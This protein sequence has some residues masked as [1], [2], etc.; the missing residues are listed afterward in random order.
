L[1]ASRSSVIGLFTSPP[2]SIF[3]PSVLKF[4]AAAATASLFVVN[5]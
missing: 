1:N 2:T 4:F 3:Q 5:S